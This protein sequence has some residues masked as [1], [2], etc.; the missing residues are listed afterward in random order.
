MIMA[1]ALGLVIGL[2]GGLWL[3]VSI[4]LV[5]QTLG[6]PQLTTLLGIISSFLTLPAFVLG[7]GWVGS[8]M[9]DVSEL[10]TNLPAYL[11]TTVTVMLTIS[12]Y[13]ILRLIIRLGRMTA[14]PETTR[15]TRRTIR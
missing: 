5:S 4:A 6:S 8:R 3:L 14:V 10:R 9:L 7:G 15:A 1:I 2:S 13:S 11:F 12:A